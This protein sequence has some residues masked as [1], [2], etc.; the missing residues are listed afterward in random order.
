MREIIFDGFVSF[1]NTNIHFPRGFH[2]IFI[3]DSLSDLR[4]RRDPWDRFVPSVNES[5]FR[6]DEAGNWKR[7]SFLVDAYLR[8]SQWLIA[9]ERYAHAR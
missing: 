8:D 2:V 9:G 4:F 3:V 6:E 1:S 7:A 5:S